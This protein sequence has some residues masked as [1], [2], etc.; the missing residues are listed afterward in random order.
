MRSYHL[1]D[2]P[3]A[4]ARLPLTTLGGASRTLSLQFD[5]WMQGLPQF[6]TELA[7]NHWTM[8]DDL[9]DKI[10]NIP[11]GTVAQDALDSNIS[12]LIK[13]LQVGVYLKPA[14]VPDATL[15]LAAA[16]AIDLSDPTVLPQYSDNGVG[17]EPTGLPVKYSSGVPV[18]P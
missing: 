12:Y 2:D 15:D 11:A 10:I 3:I 8:T 7:Q 14:L 13:P 18:N 16:N 4:L 1:L 9:A 6:D 5:G 17:A